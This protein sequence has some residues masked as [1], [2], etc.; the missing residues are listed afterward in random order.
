[1]GMQAWL[2]YQQ[3]LRPCE[4]GLTLNVDLACTAVLQELPVPIFLKQSLGISSDRDLNEMCKDN[5]RLRRATKAIA[6]LTVIL[7][8]LPYPLP[9]IHIQASGC[10]LRRAI[11]KML[12]VQM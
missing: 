1:M 10:V 12:A 4:T 7:L 6:S 9:V 5:P 8:R 11:K 3:S 2:G